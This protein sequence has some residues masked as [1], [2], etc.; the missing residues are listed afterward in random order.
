[1]LIFALTS[2]PDSAG[3]FMSI[4]VLAVVGGIIYFIVN[5]LSFSRSV[6][7][8]IPATAEEVIELSPG[9]E[10][11]EKEEVLDFETRLRKLESLKKD[12][13]LTEDEYRRKREKILEENW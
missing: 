5:L 2:M 7:E 1:M 8:K 13:L 12:G 4:W 3:G 6:K 10:E 9:D 11:E